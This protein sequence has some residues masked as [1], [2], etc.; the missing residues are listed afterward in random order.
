LKEEVE[1]NSRTRMS[2]YEISIMDFLFM[3][4]QSPL[5]REEQI[6]TK[7]DW[8]ARSFLVDRVKSKLDQITAA[9]AAKEGGNL[10]GN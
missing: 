3:E 1:E 8:E 4:K 6:Q 2:C 10:R 9:I 7:H 5:D